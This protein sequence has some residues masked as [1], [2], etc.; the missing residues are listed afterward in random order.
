MGQQIIAWGNADVVNAVD[1]LGARDYTFFSAVPDAQRIGAPS[2]MATYA[3]DADTSPLRLSL[4]W[5]PVFPASRLLVP[6]G[7]LP[8]GV[9]LLPESRPTPS[10]AA[11]EIG[12]KI[13]WAPGGWDVALV[14]FRGY[15]HVSEPFV[16]SVSPSEIE[17][18]RTFH[19]YVAGGLEASY[20][21][22]DWVFRFEGAYVVTQNGDGRNPRIQPTHVDA[23]AGVERPFGERVRASAQAI[24]RA[25]PHWMSPAALGGLDG[26]VA[27]VNAVMLNYTHVVRPGGTLRVTYTSEDESLEIGA[28][29]MA[30]AVGFDWAVQPEI[31]YRPIEPLKLTA[32]VQVFGGQ[33]NSLGALE[34]YSGVFAQ[35]TYAF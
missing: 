8:P 34:P 22:G 11:S 3:P 2:V 26:A 23:I 7:L 27:Q 16:A 30:Y 17:I 31:A 1:L 33:K 12:V 25:H 19:G 20:A 15:N 13:G 5:Q 32:G 24:V 9:V 14:G 28:A 6:K 29:G 18:G 35:S 4:V 21:A 10:L